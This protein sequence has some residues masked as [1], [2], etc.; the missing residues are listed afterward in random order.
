MFLGRH[1]YH[2]TSNKYLLSAYC[3][4]IEQLYP[5]NVVNRSEL[6]WNEM[7][8]GSIHCCFLFST[9]I[10]KE[11]R[12]DGDNLGAKRLRENVWLHSSSYLLLCNKYLKHLSGLRLGK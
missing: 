11:K 10:W 12:Q 5:E 7:S 9:F 1:S 4:L 3:E 2:S 8:V 6:A